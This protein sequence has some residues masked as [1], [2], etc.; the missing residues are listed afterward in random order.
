LEY[1]QRL[2]MKTGVSTRNGA[3]WVMEVGYGKGLWP[4]WRLL[5][6]KTTKAPSFRQVFGRNLSVICI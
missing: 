5:K 4:E 1:A 3:A 2:A 6:K